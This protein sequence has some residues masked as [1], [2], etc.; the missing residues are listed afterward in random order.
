MGM[1]VSSFMLTL[2]GPRANR[3]LVGT[4][5][6]GMAKEALRILDGDRV[7]RGAEG[8]VQ[9]VHGAAATLR[10]PVF[11]LAQASSIGLR[12]GAQDGR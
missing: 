7:E 8:S 5:I 11:T 2:T 12:S 3:R 9:A 10:N 1:P 4:G 6:A